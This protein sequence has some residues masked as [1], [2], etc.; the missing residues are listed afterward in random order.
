MAKAR[1]AR[2]LLD[3]EGIGGLS[4]MIFAMIASVKPEMQVYLC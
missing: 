3:S 4:R 1:S 2:P